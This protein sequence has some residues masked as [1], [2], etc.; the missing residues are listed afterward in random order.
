MFGVVFIPALP[1]S[2]SNGGTII[3]LPALHA[4]DFGDDLSD[5]G[6]KSANAIGMETASRDLLDVLHMMDSHSSLQLSISDHS[7]DALPALFP[8]SSCGVPS[9]TS[10]SE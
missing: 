2:D 9:L 8:Q 10:A 6:G 5:G 1:S 7:E 4:G 3:R